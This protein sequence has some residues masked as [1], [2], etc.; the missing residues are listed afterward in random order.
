MGFSG[1]NS[2]IGLYS[3]YISYSKSK[4]SSHKF[5]T[6][7]ALYNKV[8]I[9]EINKDSL[10]IIFVMGESFI[11]SHAGVYGYP[12]S[13]SYYMLEQVKCAHF[14]VFQGFI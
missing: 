13:T 4:I 2:I 6:D 12:L 10:N 14:F 3:A 1:Q 11:K 8:P 7:M 9:K 5:I